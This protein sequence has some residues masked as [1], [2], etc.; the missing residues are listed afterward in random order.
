M[1]QLARFL[2]ILPRKLP[3][4]N[5]EGYLKPEKFDE[6]VEAVK[7]MCSF[8]EEDGG[9]KVGTPS[10]ALKLGHSLK[11]C[12]YILWGQA[13]RSKDKERE[14]SASNLEKLLEREWCDQV[15]RHSLST[16]YEKKF[17]KSEVLPPTSDLQVVKD[18]F[19]A[20]MN[21]HSTALKKK[22]DKGV[23][24]LLAEVTLNRLVLFNKQKSGE[25]SRLLVSTYR[26]RPLW[27]Q[28]NNDELHASILKTFLSL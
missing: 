6:L 1:R 19:A 24:K 22:P 25:T 20:G 16:M 23:W 8:K 10:L 18:H 13:V 27:N 14:E 7:M 11:K 28:R 5:L 15:S 9:T 21:E 2:I 17:N 26:N 3:K 12:V 4:S